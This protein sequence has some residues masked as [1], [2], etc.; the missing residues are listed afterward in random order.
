MNRVK[1]K[2]NKI[3][4]FVHIPYV[5]VVD[6]GIG[7]T[8][9]ISILVLMLTA[10]CHSWYSSS[11]QDICALP[12]ASL[13]CS[14]RTNINTDYA[15]LM[16][17]QTAAFEELFGQLA[18]SPA[19]ITDLKSAE[20]AV[21]DLVV[22][23]KLNTDLTSRLVLARALE[24]FV[25]DAKITGRKLQRFLAKVNGALDTVIAINKHAL[26]GIA[27]QVPA[28]TSYSL[29][30]YDPMASR[31]AVVT[32]FVDAMAAISDQIALVA[33]HGID[34]LAMLDALEERLLTIHEVV[35]RE[36]LSLSK[37]KSQTLAELWTM[38]GGNKAHIRGLDKNLR[39]L[40]NVSGYRLAARGQVTRALQTLEVL[41]ED[42]EALR[43]KA[44]TPSLSGP[45]VSLEV[46]IASIGAGVERLANVM[47]SAREMDMQR[48]GIA[49]GS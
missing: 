33:L 32:T 17:T 23:I 49:G 46:H 44:I 13:V 16:S 30:F 41:N 36:N 20:M 4:S 39:L 26:S 19:M 8:S 45:T 7:W 34:C 38:L 2:D 14:G 47:L 37:A 12:L 35:S 1:T 42:L 27:T 24:D 48:A 10:L 11:L 6:K 5:H 21:A 40:E 3:F 29:S 9:A 25:L 22:A 43:Q 15:G 31:A 28:T 18:N